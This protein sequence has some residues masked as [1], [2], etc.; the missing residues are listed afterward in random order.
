MVV[1]G[2]GAPATTIRTLPGRGCPCPGLEFGSGIE[3]SV[4]HRGSRTDQ[5]DAV[6]F[7]TTQ[8]LVAVDLADDDV[9][10]THPAD[11]VEHPPAVAVELGERVEVHVAI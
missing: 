7:D 6:F 4:E 5:R 3:C 1:V 10:A 2:G 8:D 9:L 11:G